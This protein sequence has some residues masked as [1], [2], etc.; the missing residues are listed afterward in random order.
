MAEL[1]Q[2]MDKALTNERFPRSTGYDS[3]WVA[4]NL[5]GPNA[6]WLTEWLCERMDLK[7]GMRVLDMGCGRCLSSVFLA[8]ELDVQ[9]FAADLWIEPSENLQR[10]AKAGVADRVV[11][12][13]V[14]AHALPFAQGYFDAVISI[15][16]Y[17]YFGTDDLYFSQFV[18]YLKQGGQIGIV[19]PGTIREFEGDI[20]DHLLNMCGAA[21][22]HELF[23]LHTAEWWRRHW[24]RTRLAEVEL[25]DT[26]A[27]GWRH[28]LQSIRIAAIPNVDA[29]VEALEAD[30]GRYLGLVR[31]IARRV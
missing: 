9:V 7:P 21:Y 13:K 6:L 30:A 22:P 31:L 8:R 25:A 16:A 1:P 4:E 28:W 15:D 14:E 5:M 10:L 23:S 11:P 26:L 12:L 27:D 29:E 20:P 24:A 17:H 19:V 3:K 2:D 18:Q